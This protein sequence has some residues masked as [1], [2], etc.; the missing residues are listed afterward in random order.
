MALTAS[1]GSCNDSDG[2]CVII[3]NDSNHDPNSSMHS[4][5][6]NDRV[7]VVLVDSDSCS[8]CGHSSAVSSPRHDLYV[9]PSNDTCSNACSC[10][11]TLDERYSRDGFHSKTED[12]ILDSEPAQYS[13]GVACSAFLQDSCPS[14]AHSEILESSEDQTAAAAASGSK[15]ART[16]RVICLLT[17]FATSRTSP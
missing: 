4:T 1:S 5:A 8:D 14:C 16:L 6:V 12:S 7:D 10:L 9:F 3:L 11:V 17:L 15:L 13:P 2:T